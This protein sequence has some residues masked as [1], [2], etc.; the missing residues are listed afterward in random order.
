MPGLRESTDAGRPALSLRASFGVL[1]VGIVLSTAILVG[2]G[3]RALFAMSATDRRLFEKAAAYT[4]LLVELSEAHIEFKIQI[5]EWKNVLIRGHSSED[6][7][8]YF[9]AFKEG[10]AAVARRLESARA[11]AVSLGM[12]GQDIVRVGDSIRV[13]GERYAA[14]FA[15]V[16]LS[17]TDAYRD[18]DGR[19]R[20]LDR[21]PSEA[22]VALVETYHSRMDEVDEEVRRESASAVL[23]AVTTQ[24]IIALAAIV[25]MGAMIAFISR[26]VLRS[27]GGEP[28]E[29]AAIAE[30][31]ADGDLTLDFADGRA[32]IGAYAAI[33]R[34][35]L[36]LMDVVGDV[37]SAVS[38]VASGSEQINGSAQGLAQG[39]T[40]QASA[41]EEVSAAMEEMGSSIKQNSDNARRT[42]AISKTSADQAAEGGASV[43]ETVSA[44]KE[45]ASRISI[46]E[47]IARQ[48]NLLA[49]NAAIEAARA[50]EVGKGFAVVA[51]EVRKLA[52][53]SQQAASEIAELSSRSVAVAEAASSLIGRVVPAIQNTA[54]LVMEISAASA[55][56]ETGSRQISDALGQLDQV[57][58]RNAASSEELAS[59]A[60]ELSGQSLRL[61]ESISFFRLSSA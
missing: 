17:A 21:E 44:M 18:L 46:I 19:V 55:E 50:G 23:S 58:Q 37:Q 27:V 54:E 33:K 22:M 45:I 3:L 60:E 34:M 29:I 26:S 42:E 11:T 61:S 43:N 36:K 49:L 48:T 59:M 32:E 28:A 38:T 47:E 30:R 52:E 16:D 10:G 2:I 6:R 31:V 39:A 13:L 4:N 53:R 41:A 8:G 9:A 40:E 15:E 1:A 20:G 12:D 57:V 7:D 25:F 24:G 5:Q 56:Q 35:S 51:G 14:A